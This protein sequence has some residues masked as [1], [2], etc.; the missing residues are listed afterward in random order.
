MEHVEANSI[1]GAAYLT[2]A[3][4]TL[5]VDVGGTSTDIGVLV[6]GFPRESSA[7]VEIGGVRLDR[8]SGRAGVE[9]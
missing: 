8:L 3:T 7:A 4:D 1:R 5:V 9:D 2:G 6:N